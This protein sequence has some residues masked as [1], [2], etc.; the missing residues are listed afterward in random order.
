MNSGDERVTSIC[1][2]IYYRRDKARMTTLAY[3]RFF[4]YCQLAQEITSDAISSGR[5]L[6][7]L[8]I[9]IRFN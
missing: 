2:T 6:C 5:Y 1:H 7:I 3:L 9:I 4:F 8:L